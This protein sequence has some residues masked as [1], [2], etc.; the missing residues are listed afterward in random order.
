M[1]EKYSSAIVSSVRLIGLFREEP[2]GGSS[3]QRPML[4][5]NPCGHY[6][7]KCF[8][9]AKKED[10]CDQPRKVAPDS[11]SGGT[12]KNASSGLWLLPCCHRFQQGKRTVVAASSP[13]L[14]RQGTSAI[15]RSSPLRSLRNELP[16]D[17]SGRRLPPTA[18]GRDLRLRAFACGVVLGRKSHRGD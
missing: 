16:G 9:V 3:Q 6:R 5:T 18:G 12:A 13:P 7:P 14:T 11:S 17:S 4:V 15:V 8:A 1:L 2:Y 10:L